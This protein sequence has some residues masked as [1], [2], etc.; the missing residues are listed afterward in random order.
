M[1]KVIEVNPDRKSEV[2]PQRY[3]ADNFPATPA[4]KPGNA[5]YSFGFCQYG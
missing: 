4:T 5:L 2:E 1:Q 3:S